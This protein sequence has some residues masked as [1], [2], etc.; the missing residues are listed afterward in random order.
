MY[1]VSAALCAAL[2]ATPAFAADITVAVTAIVEHPALDATRDLCCGRWL[3][4]WKR[5]GAPTLPR[6]FH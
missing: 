5:H 3:F 1:K 6:L 4:V 2:L